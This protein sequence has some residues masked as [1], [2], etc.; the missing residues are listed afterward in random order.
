MFFHLSLLFLY[1]CGLGIAVTCCL[2]IS[3]SFNSSAIKYKFTPLLIQNEKRCSTSQHI[4]CDFWNYL[5]GFRKQIGFQ[6]YKILCF[7][8]VQE[9]FLFLCKRPR[10]PCAGIFKQ[11]MGARNRVGIGLSYRPTRLHSL[12]ELVPWTRLLGSLKV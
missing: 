8:K 12:V 7:A 4:I 1:L 9:N 2:S 6:K 3:K 5:F 10:I 11:S